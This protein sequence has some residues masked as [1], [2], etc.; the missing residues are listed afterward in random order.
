MKKNF[1]YALLLIAMLCTTAALAQDAPAEEKEDKPTFSLA[2]SVDTYFHSSFKTTNPY[3]GG[4]Y[5]PSTSFADLRGFSLGMVNLIASYQGEK[6]G[7]V[8]DLVF[9]P[10]GQAAVFGTASG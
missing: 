5:G 3:M 2:G 7:F 4:S 1:T 6:S 8:G 10:R 9:G